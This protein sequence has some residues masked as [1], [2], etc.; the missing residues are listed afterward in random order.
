MGSNERKFCGDGLES[1]KDRRSRWVLL[2]SV[3]VIFEPVSF[4]LTQH[5]RYLGMM[6]VRMSMD[7]WR[8]DDEDNNLQFFLFFNYFLNSLTVCG[9]WRV[10]SGNG[11]EK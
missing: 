1:N 7:G 5:C 10:E 6:V 8:I 3:T 4:T 11:N 2:V 9:D